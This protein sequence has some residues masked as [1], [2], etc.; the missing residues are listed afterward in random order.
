MRDFLEKTDK[1]TNLCVFIEKLFKNA[2]A[3]ALF[4][5]WEKWFSI[6]YQKII[7][8]I[9]K[10]R[11]IDTRWEKSF[12]PLGL[13]KR[14][15]KK[16]LKIIFSNI[17]AIQLTFGCSGGCRLCGV[18][19]ALGIRQ[20]ISFLQ[21]I[22]LFKKYGQYLRLTAP[23]L[24]WASE[25]YDYLSNGWLFK[26]TYR[27]VH[28]LAIKYA[29]YVPSITTRVLLDKK[30]TNFIAKG[31]NRVSVFGAPEE[32][33]K[34]LKKEINI[35]LHGKNRTHFKGLGLSF[36]A[37]N[38]LYFKKR[39][40]GGIG[41]FN[42]ILLTPRG[43]YNIVQVPVSEKYPQGQ[44]VLPLI[45]LTGKDIKVGDELAD[46][47]LRGLI[48]YNKLFKNVEKIVSPYL[49]I[50][51]NGHSYDVAIDKDLRIK[52]ILPSIAQEKPEIIKLIR[53]RIRE[54]HNYHK[55]N[56]YF[57]TINS[58]IID[59]IISED[60]IF[61][62]DK[63]NKKVKFRIKNIQHFYSGHKPL[64][65]PIDFES[66]PLPLNNCPWNNKQSITARE[67]GIIYGD[68]IKIKATLNI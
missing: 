3:I 59:K 19:A 61:I 46:V 21:L 10:K 23:L 56:S 53:N 54:L 8:E 4:S 32:R 43:L 9:T 11:M 47:M 25:P 66:L 27:D 49:T 34:E 29:K 12:L 1:E 60:D 30:W 38:N 37:T 6:R 14:F 33:I 48:R 36:L 35:K 64:K 24:Y 55:I 15:S 51:Q 31:K 65:L 40:H 2:S 44:I 22:N 28:A 39:N 20:H 41:C 42:G 26:K 52:K 50:Y 17:G 67:L 63:K 13:D 5:Y 45:S 16:E 68:S 62:C 57:Y 7:D 18:D 58:L